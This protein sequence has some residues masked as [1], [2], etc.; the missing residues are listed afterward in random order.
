MTEDNAPS[1]RPR[2]SFS[3]R[4]PDG[5]TL[6][7]EVCETCGFVNYVNPKIVAGA[8]IEHDGQILLCRR[9]IDPRHGYWT[10]PAGFMEQ[11]ESAEHA[12]CR[13]A[14]E[15]ACAEIVIERLLAV[16]SIPRISQVQLIYT[17]RLARP[18]FA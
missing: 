11:N 5:D 4:V 7:R 3:L 18:E 13:E 2:I 17:A 8:V 12:A 15:E 6:S 9:A 1:K 14:R 10:I 16:Y